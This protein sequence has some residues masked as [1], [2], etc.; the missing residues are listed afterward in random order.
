MTT[1]QHDF[2]HS[3][4]YS[5]DV[6]PCDV[7][8][9]DPR[10]FGP[11]EGFAG[12][13]L[14]FFDGVHL[15]HRELI[16]SLVYECT[17]SGLE[18]AVFS[19]DRYPKQKNDENGKR[20]FQGYIH[21][22]NTRMN[23]LRELGVER[24]YIQKFDEAF[25]RMSAES[26]LDDVLYT[27]L[28][29]R[30]VVVGADFRFGQGA[31]GD[32][33]L[34][35]DWAEDKDVRVIVAEDIRS[36]GEVVSSTIIREAIIK[37]DMETVS[38]LLGAD[39]TISGVVVP[40]NALGRTIGIPTANIKLP[41]GQICPPFGVYVTRTRVGENAYFS[42]TNCGLRPTINSTDDEPLI[43]TTILN[44]E[45]NLYGKEIE[46]SFLHFQRPE[47]KFSSFL[48]LVTQMRE[49]MT[50]AAEWQEAHEVLWKITEK[51][52]VNIWALPS[53]R[54][55]S[56]VLNIS[57]STPADSERSAL[58][59]LL[60]RVL[61]ACS[62]AYPTRASLARKLD[63]LYGASFDTYIQRE[64][65]WQTVVFN[66]NAVHTGVDGSRPFHELISLVA[67]CVLKPLLDENG[68]LDAAIVE[69]EKR[70]L[71]L[72]I[73]ARKND[74]AKYAFDRMLQITCGD[75]PQGIPSSGDPR[76]L[77]DIT[78]YQLTAAWR[79][80][81]RDAEIS[82]NLAGRLDAESLDLLKEKLDEVPFN[83]NRANKQ[84]GKTPAPFCPGEVS[85]IRE[86][87]ALEQARIALVYAGLPPYPSYKVE[88]VSVLNSMLGAHAHSLLFDVVRER[89]GLAY[90]ISSAPLRYLSSIY[91]SAGVYPE[92]IDQAIADIEAQ[93]ECLASGDVDRRIFD[94]SKEMVRN[95]L[96]SIADNMEQL[97]LFK[98][99]NITSGRNMDVSDSL[100]LLA[101]VTP[102]DVAR[103]AADLR[104]VTTYVLLPETLAESNA[105]KEETRS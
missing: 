65:D 102:E 34:L 15:G 20:L 14:G 4:N 42:V 90:S 17:L 46:V 41:K 3:G 101:E 89:H 23:T 58:H 67:D 44:E 35:R 92:S 5:F 66:G 97:L 77:R 29:A 96:L 95:Q 57:F 91:V 59:A 64:G 88:A 12:V 68:V 80:W 94:S 28:K 75:N 8:R 105:T 1:I 30:L 70:S 61:T 40:G 39:F 69:Q 62:A 84:A 74:R 63:E 13:A 22:M 9:D 10:T 103:I 86:C 93:I 71:L 104:R 2:D 16:R 60:S 73:E 50:A 38:H 48:S 45:I 72:E 6:L 37:A 51:R 26:F 87:A 78:P 7:L 55:H 100:K 21:D 36:A 19:M 52:G 32:V 43:E 18:P 54:F 11:R 25:A 98:R 31:K 24:M 82:I 83:A 56:C 47:R 99:N 27:K 81:L 53:R 79:D 76:F 85:E 33:A 49:D